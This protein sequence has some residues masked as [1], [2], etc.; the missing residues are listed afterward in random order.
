MFISIGRRGPAPEPRGGGASKIYQL[1]RLDSAYFDRG[2]GGGAPR[3]SPVLKLDSAYRPPG[4]TAF[5]NTRFLCGRWT[6]HPLVF[7][8]RSES[9]R[10]MCGCQIFRRLVFNTRFQEYK[11]F[12]PPSCFSFAPPGG[13][14]HKHSPVIKPYG[15]HFMGGGGAAEPADIHQS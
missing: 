8:T 15:A 9:T 12:L 4:N 7:N 13:G 11:V 10:F 6:F 14:A 2:R 5:E 3:H 1:L